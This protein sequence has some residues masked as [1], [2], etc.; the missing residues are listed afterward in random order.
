[1]MLGKPKYAYGNKVKF[2]IK[3]DDKEYE[4]V[5][6]VYIIDKYGTFEDNSDVSYDIM[7]DKCPLNNEPCLFKHFREDLIE[8][9]E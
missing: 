3:R 1:M 8:K 4:L 9:V 2:K 7:V 6:E 5:G